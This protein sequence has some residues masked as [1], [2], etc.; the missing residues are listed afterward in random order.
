MEISTERL[1]L[2]PL[3]L[4]QLRRYIPSPEDL[5]QEL[6]FEVSRDFVT[7]R[8]RRAITMK[9]TK[10]ERTAPMEH[11]WYTYWLI[12]VKE[13]PYGAGLAGF[14]GI[15][16]EEGKIEIGYGIDPVYQNSG[17]TT[18]AVIGLIGWAFQDARCR[19]VIAP[20]TKKVNAASNRVLEKAGMRV[21]NETA[22]AFDW[23]I[24]KVV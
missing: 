3:T 13:K 20:D 8:L 23:K 16:D 9:L 10:M 4:E 21:Y 11:N 5:E 24:D 19:T 15:P 7:D 6:G 1:R 22:D 18:E 14:K 2:I 12:V 17:Y